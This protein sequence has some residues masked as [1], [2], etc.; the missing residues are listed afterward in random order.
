MSS[1]G[2]YSRCCTNSTEWPKNGL[3][4][5]PEMKP[6][7]TCRGAQVEPG[8][9][10]EHRRDEESGADRRGLQPVASVPRTSLVRIR[11][12]NLL[13]PLVLRQ[14]AFAARRL[15]E[16]P[17]MTVSV[18]MPS[19]AAVKLVRMRCRS[20]GSASAWMSSVCTCDRP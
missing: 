3:R 16:Q 17:L 5:M 19:E 6:S 14:F 10:G 1:P 8:D 4:C 15:L 11:R 18:V 7:T 2:M 9:A 12:E 20:T 13:E